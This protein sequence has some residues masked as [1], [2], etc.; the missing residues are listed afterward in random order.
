MFIICKDGTVV[1]A[2]EFNDSN[3]LDYTEDFRFNYKVSG[4]DEDTT[5]ISICNGKKT[6]LSSIL[7][8]KEPNF[9]EHS[10]GHFVFDAPTYTMYKVTNGVINKLFSTEDVH[11]CKVMNYIETLCS[12]L[13]R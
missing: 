9:E 3:I 1:Q 10:K 8:G 6:Y 13:N 7:K 2:R 4:V 12:V 11:S 5:A